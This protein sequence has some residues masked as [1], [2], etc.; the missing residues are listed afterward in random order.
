MTAPWVYILDKDVASGEWVL[1]QLEEVGIAAYRLSTITDLLSESEERPPAVCLMAIRPPVDRVLALITELTQ[2]PRF[3]RTA[4]I[5]MGPGQYK[6]VAFEAGADDYITTPPDVIELRKRVRLYLDRAALEARVLLETRITQEMEALDGVVPDEVAQEAADLADKPPVTL[7]EHAAML[8]QERN[9]L[10]TILRYAN[11]AIALIGVDGTVQYVNPAWE[12]MIGV[13]ATKVLG[14]PLTLPVASDTPVSLDEII[15]QIGQDNAWQG[16]VRYKLPD[17]R[18]SE[19]EVAVNPAHSIQGEIVGYVVIQHNV[20]ERKAMEELKARFLAD[21]AVEMR[22]PVTNIKMRQ[23][24]LQQAPPEESPMHFQALERETERLSLLVDAMLELSRLDAGLTVLSREQVNLN[25]LTAD[26]VVYFSSAAEEKGV[27]L[28]LSPNDALPRVVGDPIKLAR[29]LGALIDNAI[30]YTPEGGHIHVQMGIET[31][32]GGEFVT[33]QVRDTGMGIVPD[34]IPHIFERFFRSER[35]RD[36]GIR[37]VG[38]GLAIAHE[39]VTRHNGT[40]TVE[41][42]VNSGSTFT[43]WLPLVSAP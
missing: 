27:T 31:W 8:T 6:R 20:A 26:V 21:A 41:S 33:I 4:F 9:R 14:K 29:A 22:T 23:Y 24:L 17:G 32:T 18:V 2:E 19:A 11:D 16:E 40:I 12:R 43:I 42:Q 13:A 10:D 25:Q 30:T 28:A 39:I 15:G 5:L 36:V 34:A 38:L 7:L 35:V 1:K 37:G 3:A